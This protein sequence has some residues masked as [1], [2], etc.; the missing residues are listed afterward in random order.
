MREWSLALA[1]ILG[2]VLATAGLC[3]DGQGGVA[4]GNAS[5]RR[6]VSPTANV[7][8][9]DPDRVVPRGNPFER[10]PL[11]DLNATR[12]RPLFSISRRP[13]RAADPPPTPPLPSPP[14]ETSVVPSQPPLSLVGTIVGSGTSVALLADTDSRTILRVRLGEQSYGWRVEEIGSRSVVIQKDGRLITLQLPQ[15]DLKRPP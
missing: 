2:P 1:V 14:E 11:S 13:A 4:A 5:I 12:D 8:Q 7:S 15:P 6:A 3:D 9:S 10:I